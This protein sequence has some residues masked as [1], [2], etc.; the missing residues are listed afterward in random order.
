MQKHEGEGTQTS[1]PL[2]SLQPLPFAEG[3]GGSCVAQQS[4]WHGFPCPH[5]LRDAQA[6]V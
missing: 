5:L 4:M 1:L 6:A 3:L 2:G